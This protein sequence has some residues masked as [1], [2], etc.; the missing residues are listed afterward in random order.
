M[1]FD[2]NTK[3]IRTEPHTNEVPLGIAKRDEQAQ[4]YLN[5]I[6]FSEHFNI[7]LF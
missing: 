7:A 5:F 3:C 4:V 1:R 6:V 2:S